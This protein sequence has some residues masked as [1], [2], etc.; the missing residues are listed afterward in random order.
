MVQTSYLLCFLLQ[1]L[2]VPQAVVLSSCYKVC[3]ALLGCGQCLSRL[4][5]CIWIQTPMLSLRARL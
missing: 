1:T 2:R 4:L 5:C 3:A